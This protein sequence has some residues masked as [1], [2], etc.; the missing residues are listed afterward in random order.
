MIALTS[1]NGS[2]S[3]NE[4]AAQAILSLKLGGK[5]IFE[6]GYSQANDVSNIL[7]DNGFKNITSWQDLKGLDR[8]TYAEKL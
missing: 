3:F 1:K 8:F 7:E 5:I 4:I 2:H 6:H